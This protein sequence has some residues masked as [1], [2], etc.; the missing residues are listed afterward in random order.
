MSG[1]IMFV[2]N[3]SVKKHRNLLNFNK[4]CSVLM[5]YQLINENFKKEF[6]NIVVTNVLFIYIKISNISKYILN[7]YIIYI[8]H[9]LYCLK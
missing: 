9:K 2:N 6:V 8:Y 1:F 5:D 3:E 7:I 4:I